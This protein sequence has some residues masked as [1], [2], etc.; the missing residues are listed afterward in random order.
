MPTEIVAIG[1][2]PGSPS[3][4]PVIFPG[5]DSLFRKLERHRELHQP[6]VIASFRPHGVVVA[7]ESQLYRLLAQSNHLAEAAADRDGPFASA[8]DPIGLNV[9]R[10]TD[11]PP[12]LEVVAREGIEQQ[13]VGPIAV[14]RLA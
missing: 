1:R 4:D 11:G 8:G 3:Q 10:G 2:K 12:V 6:R 14:A 9:R 13:T 5:G 7:F